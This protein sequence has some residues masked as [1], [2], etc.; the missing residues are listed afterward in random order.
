MKELNKELLKDCLELPIN[1]FAYKYRG[2]KVKV[3]DRCNIGTIVG[4][5]RSYVD[6]LLLS[7]DNDKGWKMFTNSDNIKLLMPNHNLKNKSF[8]YVLIS[9]I[10][11][12]AL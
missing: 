6:M 2:K 1:K 12:F 8:R 9:D 4:Y 3:D 11:S 7:V 10:I 5:K